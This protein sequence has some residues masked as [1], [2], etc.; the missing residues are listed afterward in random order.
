MSSPSPFSIRLDP[1]L[2][3]RLCAAAKKDDRTVTSFVV[4]VLRRALMSPE[5]TS[6]LHREEVLIEVVDLSKDGL[7]PWRLTVNGHSVASWQDISSK[8]DAE[9][10]ARV[11]RLAIR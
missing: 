7:G 3:K 8:K 6:P 4:H 10:A 11:L 2:K 9:E 5:E 1:A